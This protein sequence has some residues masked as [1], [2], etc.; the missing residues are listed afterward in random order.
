MNKTLKTAN[1]R[2]NLTEFDYVLLLMTSIGTF[3]LFYRK[4][5]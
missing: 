2:P 1:L 3:F 4:G 5:Q